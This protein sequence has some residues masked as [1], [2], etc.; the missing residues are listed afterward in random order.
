MTATLKISDV[1]RLSFKALRERRLRSALTI[2][3]VVVG[4]ASVIALMAQTVGIQ[5]SVISV[6][7]RI[8]PTTIMVVGSSEL[9]L[10]QADIAKIAEI[11]N[12]ADVYPIISLKAQVYLGGEQKAVTVVG[13]QPEKLGSFLGDYNIV[14]G[15][16]YP[17]TMAPIALVGHDLA[18][19]QENGV[20]EIYVGQPLY[21]EVMGSSVVFRVSGILDKYGATV[22]VSPDETIFISIDAAMSIARTSSYTM[23]IVKVDDPRNVEMVAEWLN[24]MYGKSARIITVRQ[25]TEVVSTILN[26]F[27]VLLVAIASISLGVA[28]LGIMN[29]MFVSVIERTREIGVLKA[30]GFKDR[31]VLLIFLFQAVI[32][33]LIGGLLGIVAGVGFSEIFPLILSRIFSERP[34]TPGGTRH[35]SLPS[36]TPI[37]T[38]DAITMAIAVAVV[39]GLI[40]GIY[41]AWRA[42][43]MD[44]IKALRYE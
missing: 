3:S 30:I 7:E 44:P 21:G 36:Y 31:D 2:L 35:P 14:E 43:K 11:P 16:L 33:G 6:L 25:I 26:Q 13:I 39:V 19:S 20:Q 38:V 42:S 22:F 29:I 40:A 23:L 5:T 8:G 9:E 37:V 15:E 24:V 27:G 32:I 1:L 17:D 4:V 41:P 18:Y 12:V 10:T 28:G 34:A